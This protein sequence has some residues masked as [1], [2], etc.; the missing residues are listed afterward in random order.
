MR[1]F[2]ALACVLALMA[3]TSSTAVAKKG[4]GKDDGEHRTWPDRSPNGNQDDNVADGEIFRRHNSFPRYDALLKNAVTVDKTDWGIHAFFIFI[5]VF[6]LFMMPSFKAYPTHGSH[7]FEI[8]SLYGIIALFWFLFVGWVTIAGNFGH[9][10]MEANEQIHVLYAPYSPSVVDVSYG[11]RIGLRGFNVTVKGEPIYQNI[12]TT[13]TNG[14]QFTRVER[15]DY[16]EYITWAEKHTTTISQVAPWRQ[17]R[18]G[19]GLYS[20][21]VGQQFRRHQNRGTPYTIQVVAELLA[22]DGEYVRFGRWFRL[23]GY[24]THIL[25]YFGIPLWVFSMFYFLFA[26]WWGS[27]LAM[28]SGLNL[29]IATIVYHDL[30]QLQVDKL[31][32]ALPFEAKE[33][34]HEA[35]FV[36]PDY[37]WTLTLVATTGTMHFFFG[38]FCMIMFNLGHTEFWEWQGS[39]TPP[40]YS[41]ADLHGVGSVDEDDDIIVRPGLMQFLKDCFFG[42][43]HAAVQHM[44][45]A[46]HHGSKGTIN[47]DETPFSEPILKSEREAYDW[48]EHDANPGEIVIYEDH[49]ILNILVNAIVSRPG[50]PDSCIARTFKIFHFGIP[51]SSKSSYSMHAGADGSKDFPTI[52]AC[53]RDFAEH[54]SSAQAFG[55]VLQHG[56]AHEAVGEPMAI[57]GASTI[58]ATLG[59]AATATPDANTSRFSLV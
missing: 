44:K 50:R 43:S 29:C 14:A 52:E 41:E 5:G 23:A 51:G 15:I 45:R 32:F 39:W 35:V 55:I 4:Y 25:M 17:G 49:G 22:L 24:Y 7:K 53:V 46:S 13:G 48:L 40:V 59:S 27:A 33:P 2:T 9:Y 3:A 37:G 8:N 18:A 21:N 12:T 26:P 20:S 58:T 6:V 31:Q 42:R 47:L 19:L 1:T 11:L 30:T 34:P 57:A 38:L 54:D 36:V 56:P 10:W 16:N 28:F